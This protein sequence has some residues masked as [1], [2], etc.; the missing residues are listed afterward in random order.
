MDAYTSANRLVAGDTNYY[1]DVFV[2]DL[3]TR[4]RPACERGPS[5]GTQANGGAA[6]AKRRR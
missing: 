5:D 3:Q 6:K 4:H 2:R 1:P